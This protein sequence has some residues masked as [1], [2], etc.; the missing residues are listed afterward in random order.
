MRGDGEG[1]STGAISEAAAISDEKRNCRNSPHN[2]EHGQEGARVVTLQGDPG[3]ANDF[4][5]HQLLAVS[6]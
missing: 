3:F 5:K 1:D 2:A 6:S 4:S